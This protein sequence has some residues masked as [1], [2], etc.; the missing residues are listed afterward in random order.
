MNYRRIYNSLVELAR[1][2]EV[3]GYV[4]V[5]HIIPRCMGGSDEPSNLVSL[6]PEEHFIAHL[7]LVKIY[8]RESKLV[9]AASWMRSRAANH[10]QYGW[11]KRRFSEVEREAKTGIPRSAASIEKQKATIAAKVAGGTWHKSNLGKALTA[12]HRQAISNANKGKRIPTRSRS[13]IEGFVL[14]YGEIEGQRKYTDASAAKSSNT[15]D[16]YIQ[17]HGEER[18]TELWDA[19]QKKQS[20]MMRAQPKHNWSDADRERLKIQALARPIIECPHCGKQGPH[21]IMQRWHFDR[22]K[23]KP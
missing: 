14:R 2:R 7:L 11:L 18:G 1:E 13:S 12:E 8:P 23:L 4:E 6:T 9:Y 15:L 16:C 22:C 10:K 21:N 3:V 5:H 19:R 20:E 17:K